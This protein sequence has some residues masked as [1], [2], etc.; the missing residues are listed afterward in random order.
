MN[1]LTTVTRNETSMAVMGADQLVARMET[2]RDI[3]RRIMRDGT[4]YGAIPN[5]QRKVLLK[6][7]AELLAAAFQLS[8]EYD[9]TRTLLE[10]GHR[11]YMATCELKHIP[12]GALI[13]TGTGMCTTEESKYAWRKGEGENTGVLVPKE[14]WDVRK[15]RP[16]DAQQM[17]G[18]KGYMPKKIDG[19]W[20]VVRDDGERVKNPDLADQYNTVLKMAQKRALVAAVLN[21]TG[22]SDEF[23]QDVED[24]M[25]SNYDTN[26]HNEPSFNRDGANRDA[27]EGSAAQPSGSGSGSGGGRKRSDGGAQKKSNTISLGDKGVGEALKQAQATLPLDVMDKLAGLKFQSERADD[28]VLYVQTLGYLWTAFS[29]SGFGDE[30]HMNKMSDY[31]MSMPKVDAVRDAIN[32]VEESGWEGLFVWAL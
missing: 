23:T 30:G 18:G 8:I 32:E 2:V 14:Y 31:L 15:E 27:M 10:G 25:G 9:I 12:T 26:G 20:V 11:E 7:G 21:A 6:A 24:F 16:N 13:S 1:D 17:L 5:V 29:R 19:V 22:C 28:M 4:H 3:S